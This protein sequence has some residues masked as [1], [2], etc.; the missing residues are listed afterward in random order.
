MNNF[1]NSALRT[2][3]DFAYQT[4]GGKEFAAAQRRNAKL[5][6]QRG[7]LGSLTDAD[8]WKNIA[9]GTAK[10]GSL[11][12]G[13]PAMRAGIGVL[14]AGAAGTRAAANALRTTRAG[15]PLPPTVARNISARPP[16]P[17]RN[18]FDDITP[19]NPYGIPTYR[20]STPTM[21]RAESMQAIR[22]EAQRNIA[23]SQ[24]YRA[25]AAARQAEAARKAQQAADLR[26]PVQIQ[27]NFVRRA[28]KSIAATGATG[29]AGVAGG[30]KR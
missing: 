9:K 11:A 23:E 2:A 17:A 21:T 10:A 3:G 15:Q 27:S 12:I 1:L 5:Q 16:A 29:A 24:A 8:Y 13:G 6:Q 4:L 19:D 26:A 14:K 25:T 7:F 22:Q 20:A 30:R 28:T 18:I